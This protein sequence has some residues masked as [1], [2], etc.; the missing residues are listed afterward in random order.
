MVWVKNK[1]IYLYERDTGKIDVELIGD[2]QETDRIEFRIKEELDDEKCLYIQEDSDVVDGKFTI[3]I[4]K[5]VSA[6][7]QNDAE[8]DKT[9]YYGFKLYRNEEA[10]DTMLA[11][12]KIIVKKGV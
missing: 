6:L 7:L 4:S 11:V 5:T 8:E 2:I 1:T 10:I 9:Y 12:G 3:D